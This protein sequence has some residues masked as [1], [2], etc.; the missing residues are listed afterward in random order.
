M[1]KDPAAV[2]GPLRKTV[3]AV[4]AEHADAATW[5]GLRARAQAEKTPLLKSNLYTLLGVA[6]DKALAER[7]LQLALTDEPGL[8]NSAR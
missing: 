8:T 5:D 6:E 4:V 7:A 1:D 2:P 3:L